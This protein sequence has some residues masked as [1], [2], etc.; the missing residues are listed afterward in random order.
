MRS[1]FTVPLLSRKQ[2][3]QTAL[4]AGLLSNYKCVQCR[5]LRR[6]REQ[7]V[8]QSAWCT[9]TAGSGMRLRQTPPAGRKQVL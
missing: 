9:A 3:V 7:A 6:M 5:S 1:H 2:G 4:N 8:S